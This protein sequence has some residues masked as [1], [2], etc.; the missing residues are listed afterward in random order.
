MDN[1]K[2]GGAVTYQN[3]TSKTGP[4][5]GEEAGGKLQGTHGNHPKL[6][7]QEEL[8]VIQL[9]SKLKG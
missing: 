7:E 1:F 8:R 2:L 4:G 6:K 5:G 3:L 9:K